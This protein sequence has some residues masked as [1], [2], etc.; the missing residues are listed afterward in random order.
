MP[1]PIPFA[2][3]EPMPALRHYAL[4]LL[5]CVVALAV[6]LPLRDVL[7]LANTVMLFL[8]A[9]V[10][11][12]SRLGRGPAL[13]ASLV[14]V[15]LFDYFFVPPRFSFEV[16]HGLYLVTFAVMLAVSLIVGQLT[17]G[18][19]SQAR[20]AERREQATRALYDLA[21]ALAG[22]MQPAQ[23]ALAVR[24]FMHTYLGGR[25][26]L[27][28]PGPGDAL[29]P[30]TP[31]AG[32][33]GALDMQ[34]ARMAFDGG[35]AVE[36]GATDE[37]GFRRHFLPLTGASRARGV[38][39]ASLPDSAIGE[40]PLLEALASLVAT[41]VE[42][43]HFVDIAQ[44]SQL[45]AE[46]ERLRSSI[47]SA[48]SH[49]VRTPLTALYGLADALVLARPLLSGEQLE[50]A[51]AIRDQALRVN[52]M[53]GNLLDMARLQAGRVNLRKEWQALEEVVGAS[54]QL[55]GRAMD[56]H[57]VRATGFGALPLVQFDAVL[58][59]RVFCNLF[60]NAA[61]YAPPDTPILLAA[62]VAGVFVE[63]QV[64]SGGP[65]F[66]PDRLERVFGLFERGAAEMSVVGVGVGLAICRSIVEA[67]GG[68]IRAFNP[69][70]GGGCVVFTLPLGTPPAIEPET[71]E[72]G[73]G[74]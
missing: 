32:H 58:L 14:S 60:E 54:L 36:S 33:L 74:E 47:L 68:S 25:L 1:A 3:H 43:L 50:S 71:P 61:K 13:I 24:D 62:R 67:H 51:C 34:M 45:E 41:A 59:E 12:A 39:V 49:D 42:R 18:L 6:A 5:A 66:P 28:M 21:K 26:W 72:A 55:L 64:H 30:V 9:V 46:S 22:A 11:V 4:A 31:L 16:S 65:G 8:L 63:V 52:G 19:R 38:L 37:P 29:T 53:V 23:V 73:S 2:V 27:L 44:S 69:P 20:D 70:E 35:L 40:L 17:A 57:P 15:A 48:L 7:D 10:L 56:G